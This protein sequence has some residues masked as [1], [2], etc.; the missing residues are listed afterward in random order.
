M[1]NVKKMLVIVL[2]LFVFVQVFCLNSYAVATEINAGSSMAEA[3]DIPEFGVDYV[4]SL[5]STDEEDW[6]KFTTK[7]QDA[8]Y[9]IEM[10]NYSLPEGLHYYQN[11]FVFVCDA[12]GG[13]VGSFYGSY[14]DGFVSLKLENN[15][16]YY[17]R[18][19][20]ERIYEIGN[21]EL[22]VDVDY[23][24]APNEI[25][26]ANVIETDKIIASEMDGTGDIDWFA[27]VAPVAGNYTITM[28]NGDLP[29]YSASSGRNANV[30]LFDKWSQ[31]LGGDHTE[32][33][34][35]AVVSATLEKNE[36]YYIKVFMGSSALDSV[37]KYTLFI[38][39]PLEATEAVKLTKITIQSLPGKTTY[40]IGDE[41][42]ETG[43][44]VK[45]IYSN[46]TEKTITDYVISGFE[47]SESGEKMVTVSYTENYV[48]VEC[49]FGITVEEN[50]ETGFWKII[51]DFFASIFEFF[52]TLF[53]MLAA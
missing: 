1:K 43:L 27:F 7:S 16:T 10:I 32:L 11:A 48:T 15:T 38:D 31:N 2:A 41:F 50:N 53:A 40:S 6:F 34:S 12:S 4:S 21:Y 33:G 51:A 8:Y 42:D 22:S 35:D 3:V 46:G 29:S 24:I 49:T 52:L 26:N 23:D 20:H 13:E 17:I 5:A 25:E 9:K 45:A 19:T 28:N 39:S 18:V 30:N 37:G 36:T 44:V 14:G 47:S